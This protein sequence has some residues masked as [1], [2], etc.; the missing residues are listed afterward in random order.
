VHPF[1]RKLDLRSVY[2]KQRKADQRDVQNLMLHRVRLISTED[3]NYHPNAAPRPC[4]DNFVIFPSPASV[5]ISRI[6]ADQ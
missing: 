3:L 1:S 5:E 2:A 6:S 4:L